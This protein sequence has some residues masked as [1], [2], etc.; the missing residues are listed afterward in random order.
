MKVAINVKYGGFS[1]SEAAYEKLMEYGVPVRAYIEK[2]RGEDG[3]YKPEP[4]N[5]GEVI[6]D[7]SLSPASELNGAMSRLTGKYWDTWTRENRKHPLV[8]RVIEELG[9]EANG[10]CASLKVVEIPD[11][12]EWE[13]DE[14]DGWEH[15]AEKHRTWS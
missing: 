1:L 6:F 7:R 8:I 12:V 4:R 14:Y 13:I 2:V 10:R 9:A 11:D 5:D 3:L 15:V